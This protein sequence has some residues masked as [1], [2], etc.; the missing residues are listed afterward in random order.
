MT[1]SKFS[2]QSSKGSVS[3]SGSTVMGLEEPL[4]ELVLDMDGGV[5]SIM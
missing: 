4:L 5:T 3:L 1:Y 2:G